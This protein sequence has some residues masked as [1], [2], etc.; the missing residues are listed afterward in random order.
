MKSVMQRRTNKCEENLQAVA[1]ALAI[2][3]HVEVIGGGI[4]LTHTNHMAGR[5][6]STWTQT[7]TPSRTAAVLSH[8]VPV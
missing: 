2:K 6:L 4:T 7:T 1:P 5:R 3:Q 8:P